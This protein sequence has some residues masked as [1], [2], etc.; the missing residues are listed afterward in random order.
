[1]GV[2][3]T[4]EQRRRIRQL[5]KGGTKVDEV[6]RVVGCT[7]RS[8]MRVANNPLSQAELLDAWSPGA[9]R[10]SLEEREEISLGLSRGDCYSAIARQLDRSTS[11]VSREVGANGGPKH[12]RAVRAH[13]RAFCRARRPKV[14]KLT[15][16]P[17]LAGVV[18]EWLGELWSPE[19]IALRLPLL[20][21]DD[22]MMRVSHETI[23]QSIYV[24]GRG[25][26][27]K[28]LARCLRSGRAKRRPQHRI[29]RRGQLRD[30][31]MI[32]ERPAEVADRAVPGHWEGDLILGEGRRSAVGTLVERTTGYLLLLHLEKDHRAEA[33]DAAMR[34]AIQKLPGQFFRTITWDQGKE[35]AKH[36]A[37]TVDTGIQV[38]FCDPASPWQRATNENTNGLLRQYMPKGTSLARYSEAD[39]DAIARSLND[40]PRLRHGGLTPSEK[41][42]ELL[43]MTP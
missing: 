42:A 26:L 8:V 11:T 1:M 15:A 20:F 27:R 12:Y 30:M 23:Y 21:P 28:E 24:Q 19:E 29:E 36:A 4:L 22:P 17:R 35:M 33:V 18:R 13:Q 14:S 10:L 6:A 34:R 40:R 5:R 38:Y 31:V 3:L 2:N 16:C 43:A 37:F 9:G 41:L 39:L 25:E 7:L 32:T